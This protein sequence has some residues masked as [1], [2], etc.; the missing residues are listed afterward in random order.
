MKWRKRGARTHAHTNSTILKFSS[1]HLRRQFGSNYI[2]G[3]GE[4]S[5]ICSNYF[6]TKFIFVLCTRRSLHRHWRTAV[7]S[8]TKGFQT[9]PECH[10][11]NTSSPRQLLGQRTVNYENT[12]R[13]EIRS[14]WREDGRG[15]N[16]ALD[17][18]VARERPGDVW[19]PKRWNLP[20]CS[21]ALY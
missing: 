9:S 15:L 11:E 12:K 16:G 20:A 19:T 4:E 14:I 3:V 21:T 7:I 2:R 1:P 8:G 18:A 13:N 5:A 10:A 17:R 6:N